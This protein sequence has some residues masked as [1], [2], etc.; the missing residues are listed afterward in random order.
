MGRWEEG[1]VGG[2]VGTG[3]VQRGEG[4]GV[5]RGR[6]GVEWS[7]WKRGKGAVQK[8]QRRKG[9]RKRTGEKMRGLCH[10]YVPG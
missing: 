3:G 4:F 1:G 5:K 10:A 2:E 7:E 8:R 9:R 6:Q